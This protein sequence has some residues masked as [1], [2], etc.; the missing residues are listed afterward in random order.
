[1]TYMW[2]T[3]TVLELVAFVIFLVKWYIWNTI[4]YIFVE[5]VE[6]N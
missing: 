1:M 2:L 5:R 3:A 4:C 6:R